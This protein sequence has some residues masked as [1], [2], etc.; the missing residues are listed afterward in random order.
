VRQAAR[1]HPRPSRGRTRPAPAPCRATSIT[2]GA[3]SKPTPKTRNWWVAPRQRSWRPVPA[4]V[5]GA[6]LDRGR[7]R[8]R[9]NLPCFVPLQMPTDAPGCP[10]VPGPTSCRS[11]QCIARQSLRAGGGQSLLIS[12]L[13]VQVLRGAPTYVTLIGAPS[14]L[15]TS[16]CACARYGTQRGASCLAK[17]SPTVP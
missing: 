4:D 1:P 6:A 15:F 12:R 5:G 8:Q 2:I 11:S 10:F 17:S 16:P 9:G 13:K 7:P 3:A 14:P